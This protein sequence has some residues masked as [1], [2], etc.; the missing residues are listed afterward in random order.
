MSKVAVDYANSYYADPY[1][2]FGATLGYNAPKG[3]WQTWVDMRNLTDKHYAA[4]V[5]PGYDDKGQDAARSTPGE[6]MAVYV[7]VSWSLL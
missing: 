3:D 7:G 1:A 5:T 4:T 6:G 2:L